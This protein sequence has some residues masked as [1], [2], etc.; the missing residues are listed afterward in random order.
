V[1][2]QAGP[3]GEAQAQKSGGILRIYHRDSPASMSIHEE[4][5]NSVS[6]PMM[7]VFNNLVLY[8]QHVAQNSLDTIVPDL[9]ESWSWSEEGTRLTFKLREGVKWHDGKPFTSAD[10][11][12][13][14]DLLTGRATEQLRL[15]P[16]KSWW[17][18][19]AEIVTGGPSEATFVLQR[20]QPAILALI[21]SGYTPIYPCHV[22]PR[23]M[24][25]HPIGIGPFKFAEF[26][27]NDSIRLARNPD[28]W[29]PG[30]PY[31]DGIEYTIIPNRSTAILAFIAGNFDLTFPY[32]VTVPLMKDV[33]SQ[34]PQAICDLVPSNVLAISDNLWLAV[35]PPPPR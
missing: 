11:K 19:V 3:G 26:K 31:L 23:D 34:T 12:C 24:R 29:K 16:R 10:V 1:G 32:E 18:N 25:Q 6:I 5:T 4:G 14:W 22:L 8:D 30:R 28:Y 2:Q 13:T 15:N 33:K 17:N 20:P 9:A 35:I 7:A 27:P 21:A